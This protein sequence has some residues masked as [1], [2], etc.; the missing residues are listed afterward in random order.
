MTLVAKYDGVLTPLSG[1]VEVTKLVATRLVIYADGRQVEEACD[2]YPTRATIDT[3]RVEQ[4]VAD[5]IWSDDDLAPYGMKVAV[6]FVAPDGKRTVG[7]ASYIEDGDRVLESFAVE[8]IPTPVAP[9]PAEKL[10]STGLTIEDLRA[11]LT[12]LQA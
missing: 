12:E 7:A 5:G 8:D 4:F 11:L 6:P 9:T 3:A 1:I 2:P 10:A